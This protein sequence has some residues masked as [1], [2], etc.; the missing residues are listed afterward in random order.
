MSLI[1]IP[2]ESLYAILKWIILK[3]ILSR[4]VFQLLHNICQIIT[5][6]KGMPLISTLVL[7]NLI[8]YLH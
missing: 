3:Y 2:I 8:K 7:S 4:T 5:F 6:D 1:L